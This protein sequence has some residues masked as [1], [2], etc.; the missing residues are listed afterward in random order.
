MLKLDFDW[1]V[2]AKVD[3]LCRYIASCFVSSL[4]SSRSKNLATVKSQV[5]H[6]LRAPSPT[7]T[8]YIL[9]RGSNSWM[10]RHSWMMEHKEN[11]DL[12]VRVL[13]CND[14]QKSINM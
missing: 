4:E 3:D 5:N 11:I 6:G 12:K 8:A 1:D 14:V 9:D 13:G 7:V 10:V 2:N